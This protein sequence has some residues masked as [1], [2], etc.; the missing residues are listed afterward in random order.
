MVQNGPKL[1]KVEI[2]SNPCVTYVKCDSLSNAVFSRIN[3]VEGIL[4]SKNPKYN[5]IISRENR[6][7]LKR[8][9]Q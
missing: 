8:L 1:L 4:I 7:V 5:A 2:I 9:F 3:S 6:I